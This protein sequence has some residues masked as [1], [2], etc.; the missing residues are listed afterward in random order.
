MNNE[1]WLITLKKYNQD[2]YETDV[3]DKHPVKV[4]QENPN[5]Y[6]IYALPITL[7]QFATFQKEMEWQRG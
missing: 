4:V 6:L 3:F 7:E 5:W 2:R 1:Y